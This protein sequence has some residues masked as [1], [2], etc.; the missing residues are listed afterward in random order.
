MSGVFLHD[1]VSYGQTKSGASAHALGG[2]EWIINLRDIFR[3]DPFAVVGHFDYQRA[4][5]AVR[6]RGQGD[7]SVTVDD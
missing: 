3:L 7:L 6:V 4:V 5:A 1:A 2:E